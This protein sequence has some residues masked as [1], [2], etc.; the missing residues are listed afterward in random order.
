MSLQTAAMCI[1]DTTDV[2]VQTQM[3]HN[4]NMHIEPSTE[5]VQYDEGR[6][7]NPIGTTIV[8]VQR[9]YNWP[10]FGGIKRLKKWLKI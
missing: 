1:G 4:G 5:I 8:G 9:V 10:S 3:E 2:L 6:V 7:S